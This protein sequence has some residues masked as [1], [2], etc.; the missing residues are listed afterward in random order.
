[1][2]TNVLISPHSDDETLWCSFTIQREHPIIVIV[3]DSYIQVMRGNK[4]CDHLTRRQETLNALH[5]L[6]ED[7]RIKFCEMPDN[8]IHSPST[9]AAAIASR[10]F[11]GSGYYADDIIGS[12]SIDRVWAPAQEEG[13]HLHHNLV[14]KAASELFSREQI[15]RYLTYTD[16]G[17][18]RSSTQVSPL[19]G[20][21]IRRK[22]AAL[23]C[24][25]TQIDNPALGCVPHFM[26]DLHE[27]V[28]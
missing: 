15:T 23:A 21:S 27:Y 22:L 7:Y 28:L 3:Y 24:Y 12:Q 25:R 6:V 5:C 1:M 16:K 14:A 13:G 10:L 18:S 8:L 9:I 20:E 19:N 2:S 26:N 11:N 4:E 17:K